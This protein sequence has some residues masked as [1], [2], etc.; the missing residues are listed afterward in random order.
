MDCGR[1]PSNRCSFTPIPLD[2]N[3]S[4][5]PPQVYWQAQDP[6][7]QY[8][9]AFTTSP[10]KK[11]GPFM[12]GTDGST[13][14]QKVNHSADNGNFVYTIVQSGGAAPQQARVLV[15][16]GGGIIIEDS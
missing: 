11:P 1:K 5:H 16:P 3:G 10:F 9:I 14:T 2:A 7:L 15:A 4:K 6:S 12:T 8:Q 13:A